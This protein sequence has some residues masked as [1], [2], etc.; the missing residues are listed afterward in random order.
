LVLFTSGFLNFDKEIS[1]D[2]VQDVFTNLL[3]KKMEFEDLLSLK[4]YLYMSAKNA[5]YNYHKHMK[6]KKMYADEKIATEKKETFFLDKVLEEEIYF[7][8]IKSVNSL[9]QRCREIFELSL[10]GVKNAEIAIH[11][12]ISVETVKSQKKRGKKLLENLMKP[13]LRFF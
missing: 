13:L 11:M 12:K 10:R 6:V 4:S 8:L 3:Q 5:S 1:E 9:P 7:H 2:I